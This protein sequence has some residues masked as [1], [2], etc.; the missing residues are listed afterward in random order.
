MRQRLFINTPVFGG[1]FD[2]EYKEHTIPLFE[3]INK[4]EFI[5]LYST[6]TQDELESLPDNVKEILKCLRVALTKFIDLIDHA[7][8]LAND[9]IREKF[10]GQTS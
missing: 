7:I 4:G 1:H 10:V 3:R 5:I 6:V 9:Y 2:E 8:D